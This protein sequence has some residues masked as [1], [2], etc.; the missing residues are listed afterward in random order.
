MGDQPVELDAAA[1]QFLTYLRDVR[2]LSPHTLSN[3][4][5]DLRALQDYCGRRSL[6]ELVESDI[7]GWVSQMHRRGLSGSSIQRRLSATRS[8]YNYLGREAGR[9]RNP[10]A[11]VQA[12]RKPRRLPKTMDADQVDRYLSF[13]DDTPLALRDRAMAELF[14]SSGLRLSEL[15]AVDVD[16]I[17]AATQLLT[18]TG[19]GNKTR[20]VPVGS[21]A[22]NAIQQ[23]LKARPECGNDTGALFTSS[24]GGRISVRNIQD[25][26]KLQGRRAGMHQD[27]H[28]HMLRHSFAS[29]MLESS[30]DLRAVQE[31][32][33]HANIS[34]T[35]VYTHLDFQHLAKVYDAAHPRAKR[36]EQD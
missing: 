14:Y 24:R 22:M 5:R 36:R 1:E 3:Y 25:R 26:L 15:A 35:Q 21:V 11:S 13:D 20:T 18:V 10:A 2:Q 16:D 8:F 7:R 6:A 32:L 4:Q 33:G 23:W 34:T 30:G 9:P 19:K 29:H 28:P 31:L 27:V 17:D 12:P